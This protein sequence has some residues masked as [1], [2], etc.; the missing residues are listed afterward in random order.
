MFSVVEGD[1]VL[2]LEARRSFSGL[3]LLGAQNI[4]WFA[5]TIEN[6][7]WYPGDK[8]FVESFREGSKVLIVR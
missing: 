5:S 8:E 3:V 6:L 7:L 1:S 4:V 2:R